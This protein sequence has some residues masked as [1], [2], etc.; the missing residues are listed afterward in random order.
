MMSAVGSRE[1]KKDKQSTVAEEQV[2]D[3]L[4]K[5]DALKSA[6]LDGM[7]LRGL[8]DL[9]GVI[10]QPLAILFENWWRLDEVPGG[11]KR[12]TVVPNVKKGKEDPGK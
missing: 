9:A 2:I 11:W 10:L 5:L 4:E 3:N 12:A 7:H 1:R 8:K 6:G